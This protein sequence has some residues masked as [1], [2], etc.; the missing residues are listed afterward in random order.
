MAEAARNRSRW[1]PSG[2][3]SPEEQDRDESETDEL[4][5]NDDGQSGMA[6]PVRLQ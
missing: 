2:L 5:D 6:T 3:V 4:M 1:P